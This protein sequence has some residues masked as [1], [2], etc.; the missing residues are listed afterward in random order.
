MPRVYFDSASYTNPDNP[1]DRFVSAKDIQYDEPG[2][3]SKFYGFNESNIIAE[4]QF[5]NRFQRQAVQKGVTTG[6]NKAIL[7]DL[8]SSK[9]ILGQNPAQA[10]LLR[11]Y[12]AT[13]TAPEG[14]SK[15]FAAQA[16]DWAIREQGRQ[17]QTKE[18]WGGG[19]GAVLNK[20]VKYA[21]YVIAAIPGVGLPAA[22]AV[23]AG[24]SIIRGESVGQGLKKAAIVGGINLFA[25]SKAASFIKAN[26]IQSLK[27]AGNVASAVSTGVTAY[28]V[29]NPPKAPD[30]SGAI[31]RGISSGITRA[32]EQRVASVDPAPTPLEDPAGPDVAQEIQ[33]R[34][35]ATQERASRARGLA[36]TIATPGSRGL[37]RQ[38]RLRRKM[39]LG[40]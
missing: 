14:L 21:P 27:I 4:G 40:A 1:G 17:Q 28:N 18:P 6:G 37:T 30:I 38:P 19:V 9:N 12:L 15:S 2:F 8:R 7:R 39:L 25:G 35:K 29:L 33:Q 22:L 24:S 23:S 32:E 13:G 3:V 20:V 34:R 26:P 10:A 36:S 16:Y 5:L 11:D 31:S